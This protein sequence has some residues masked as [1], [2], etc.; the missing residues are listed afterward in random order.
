VSDVSLRDYV[1]RIFDERQAALDLAFSGQQEA[2]RVAKVEY[3]ARL[4]KLNELRAEVTRDRA[5]FITTDRFDG[6][7]RVASQARDAVANRVSALEN[8]KAKATGAAVVLTIIAG[9]IGAAVAKAF[10]G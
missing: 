5:L 8:W 1:E 10:G 4:E 2:L 9:A 6:E 3:D 7:Q